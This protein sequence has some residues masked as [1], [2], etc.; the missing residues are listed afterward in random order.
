MVWTPRVVRMML[1]VRQL[2]VAIVPPAGYALG[3]SP[4]FLVP[5]VVVLPGV[6]AS[7]V[8]GAGLGPGVTV[9]IRLYSC[10]GILDH[11]KLTTLLFGLVAHEAL[12]VPA[13][14]EAAS[15]RIP[16]AKL[17][18]R[19]VVIL[20]PGGNAGLSVPA[21]LIRASARE[22]ALWCPRGRR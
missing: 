13:W 15:L 18:H 20:A 10:Q 11:I 22:A 14:S 5:S 12:K 7:S 3:C 2:R 9:V 21:W 16:L 6:G 4:S 8:A 1:R 17:G 19:V